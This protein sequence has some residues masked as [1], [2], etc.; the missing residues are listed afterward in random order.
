M[1]STTLGLLQLLSRVA[2]PTVTYSS[3]CISR[4]ES[5]DESLSTFVRNNGGAPQSAVRSRVSP[6]SLWRPMER[7]KDSFEKP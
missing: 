1:E 2:G 7:V 5:K 3:V 6:S 4:T